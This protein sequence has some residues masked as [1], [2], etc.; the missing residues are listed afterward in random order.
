[1]KGFLKALKYV[2]NHPMN[3]GQ[4]IRSIRRLLWFQISCRMVPSQCLPVFSKSKAIVQREMSGITGNIYCG[5]DEFEDMTFLLHFLR[6]DDLF[7]D[8]GANV[9]SYTILTGSEVGCYVLS[10]EPISRTFIHLKNNVSINNLED[11]VRLYNVGIGAKKDVKYFTSNLDTVNH[12][13]DADDSDDLVRIEIEALDNLVKLSTP[14]VIK[15]D[16]EGYELEVLRG[17][18][19]TLRQGF[20][21]A[22]I[23]EVNGNSLRYGFTDNDIINH[24]REFGFNRMFYDPFKRQ[25]NPSALNYS[26]GNVIFCRDVEF[27]EER[28]K[29]AKPFCIRN[30]S[31]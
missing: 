16:V 7:I 26:S 18:N 5:L 28:V 9:G 25:M 6:K 27:I 11:K 22:I 4:K 2:M 17:M 14:T 1:M 13:V 10:I 19:E 31:L 21:K 8:I 24:L 12:V 3:Q 15:I 20:L 30:V 23:I 29:S